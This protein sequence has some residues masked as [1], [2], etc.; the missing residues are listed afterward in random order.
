MQ[1]V[2]FFLFCTIFF[3]INYQIL[4]SDIQKK[5]IPNVYLKY[6]LLLVPFFLGYTIVYS[7]LDWQYLA[8][9]TL[10]TLWVSFWLYYFWLWWAGDAKYLL[11]LSLFLLQTWVIPFVSNIAL[12]T[13]GYLW[14]YCLYFYLYKLPFNRAYSTYIF[15]NMFQDIKDRLHTFLKTW[16]EGIIVSNAFKKVSRFLLLFLTLFV[17]LR[18]VRM[19]IVGKFLPKEML[20][21]TLFWIHFYDYIPLIWIP[22]FIFLVIFWKILYGYVRNFTSRV[23]LFIGH[24]AP[25]AEYVDFFYT[26]I[27]FYFLSTYILYELFQSP[28]YILHKLSLIFSI[29]LGVFFIFLVL[30]Y[31]YNVTFQIGEMRYVPFSDLQKWEIV[32]KLYLLKLLWNQSYP[33]SWEDALFIKH[34]DIPIDAESCT[35]I[36]KIFSRI[37]AYH[38]KHKTAWFQEFIYIKVLNSFSFWIYIFWG[39]VITSVFWTN[40]LHMLIT[41]F[42]DFFH[43]VIY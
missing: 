14:L 13:L 33:H 24:K 42:A 1:K 29:Y 43:L 37:N 11:V 32:D 10:L 23:M 22:L 15:S 8:L 26:L 12:L 28:E 20:T 18:L 21:S 17:W 30:R 39:F 3:W 27:A 31:V 40:I 38:K 16:S 9:Q 6:L 19:Y 2:L 4:I 5:V 7:S 34:M 41:K 36:Q 25:N 35:H